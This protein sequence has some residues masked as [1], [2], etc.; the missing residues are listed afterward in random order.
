MVTHL[1]AA[2]SIGKTTEIVKAIRERAL[3]GARG[4]IA[5]PRVALARFMAY[6]LRREHGDRAWGVWH[7]GS[8][9]ANRFVGEL[10]AICC[11]PSLSRVVEKARGQGLDMNLLY[12]AVGELDFSYEL[13]SLTVN[14]AVPIKQTLRETVKT[15]A[16][17]S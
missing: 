13:L 14:Q 4:I 3:D 7:E 6:Q 2:M 11:L 1:G 5:V 10:G 16:S 15:N 9:G 12:I 17:S 8:E